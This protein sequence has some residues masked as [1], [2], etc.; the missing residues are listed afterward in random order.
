MDHKKVFTISGLI[1]KLKSIKD[2]FGDLKVAIANLDEF[3]MVNSFEIHDGKINND[4][5]LYNSFTY[6]EKKINGISTYIKEN[7]MNEFVT[8]TDIKEERVLV[9]NSSV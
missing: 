3:A 5:Y 9:L 2:A 7:G 1:D 8:I 4:T 6:V